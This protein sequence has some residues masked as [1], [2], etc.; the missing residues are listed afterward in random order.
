MG[1]VE[2]DFSR[3]RTILDENQEKRE[4]LIRQSRD[5]TAESKK[6]IFGLHRLGFGSSDTDLFQSVNEKVTNIFASLQRND[7]W[8][9]HSTFSPGLQEWIEAH[10]FHHYLKTNG[11]LLLLEDLNTL[12][13]NNAERAASLME[14]VPLL[15]YLLGI[16]DMT[17]EVMRLAVG[18][19][20]GSET[21]TKACAF[22]Q[23]IERTFLL[24]QVN[25]SEFT[26]KMST[27][28]ASTSKVLQACL[29]SVIQ[30]NEI[31]EYSE[32]K[33]V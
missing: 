22:L 31:V 29:N 33:Q 7:F 12:I 23:S 26:R 17:G 24:V 4:K 16:L 6:I 2:M 3:Y 27:L 15:D 32:G 13:W 8:G 1:D 14:S 30:K 10:A 11:E 19:P 28:S 9:F 21:A 5:I 18:A 20:G 25:S